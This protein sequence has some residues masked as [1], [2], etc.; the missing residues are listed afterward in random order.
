MSAL[1]LFCVHPPSVTLDLW[2][3]LSSSFWFIHHGESVDYLLHSS[4]S[5]SGLLWPEVKEGTQVFFFFFSRH[6]LI[7]LPFFP[8]KVKIQVINADPKQNSICS[9]FNF[10]S[11]KNIMYNISSLLECW[12]HLIFIPVFKHDLTFQH[13]I[14]SEEVMVGK[15]R[16]LYIYSRLWKLFY[17]LFFPL[18]PSFESWMDLYVHWWTHL[19]VLPGFLVEKT[20]S[21]EY[22]QRYSDDIKSYLHQGLFLCH[23]R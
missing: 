13:F 1:K 10:L 11:V 2:S 8:E 23:C 21:T 15:M 6:C 14:H 16:I 7:V 4:M 12:F 20:W 9:K 19:H 3:R 17:T 22:K 5:A 18:W